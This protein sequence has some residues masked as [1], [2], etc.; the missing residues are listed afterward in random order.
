MSAFCSQRERIAVRSVDVSSAKKLAQSLN[1]P[2][3]AAV[4][5]AGR[6]LT[7]PEECLRFFAP[8]LSQLHDPF[9]FPDM[10]KAAARIL[11]AC[12]K[13]EKITVYG[14]YDVDG[15]S[16]TVILLQALRRLGAHC[17][18]HLPHRLTEGY[19]VSESGIRQIAESGSR[20]IITVD[21]GVTAVQEVAAAKQLGMD[22]IVTDHHESKESLPA[23]IAIL[24]PM[25]PGSPYPD[26]YLAG[27]GVVLKLCQALGTQSGLG[28]ELWENCLELA[29]LGTAADIVPLIG[30]NRVITHAGFERMRQTRQ[31]GLAALIDQQGLSGKPISTRDVVFGLAPCIN[32]GGRIGDPKRG[33]EL[34]LATDPQLA[35]SYA[36]ELRT[37]NIER[38]AID[39]GVWEEACAWVEKHCSP[40]S[41]YAI[42]AGSA[43]WHAGVIGI[44]ASKLVERFHRPAILFSIG[45]DGAA[46][47]SGRSIPALHLL[48]TLEACGDLL[49]S[50]GGHKAA[51]G[52]SIK[53]CNIDRFRARL[54][55]TVRNRITPSDLQPVVTAD[56]EVTLS[57]LNGALFTLIRK[58]EP[59]GPGNMRPILFCR[60]LAHRYSPRIVGNSH[61]KMTVTG[62]GLA[63]DAIAFNFGDRIDEVS[64]AAAV[65]LAF[66]LDENEWNG[67]KNL[68]MKIRGISV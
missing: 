15:I 62:E 14:D 28:A 59:F 54:N 23:A 57:A 1:I 37:A 19:G 10:A 47:G 27:V 34:L 2:L 6:N 42:V 58:M 68:Q 43:N 66:S 22:V 46:R 11:D 38:R 67:K 60:G 55:E 40:D 49:E 56:A 45:P 36:A 16:G 48:Q 52:M 35:R 39:A 61:L 64:R 30:E 9:I 44:V 29:A 50:F 26:K 21:C 31:V 53:S 4:I 33:V 32:A 41:D 8:R 13:K 63:M 51:A 12:A 18:Y 5:L 24:N 20:L 7:D 25:V 65:S 17:D 3:C